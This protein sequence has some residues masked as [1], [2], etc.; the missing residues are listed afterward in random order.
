MSQTGG[1]GVPVT[2]FVRL[3]GTALAVLLSHAQAGAKAESPQS[4]ADDTVVFSKGLPGRILDGKALEARL[5][6]TYPTLHDGAGRVFWRFHVSA[7]PT[8][9][10]IGRDGMIVKSIEG[11]SNEAALFKALKPHIAGLARVLRL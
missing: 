8:S 9:V 10:I 11:Y 6:F 4:A 7:V 3:A 5:V 1:T 2:R